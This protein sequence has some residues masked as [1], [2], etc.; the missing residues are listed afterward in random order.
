M[1]KYIFISFFFLQKHNGAS[2]VVQ[3]RSRM[4]RECGGGGLFESYE[5]VSY[6]HFFHI[7]SQFERIFKNER[8]NLPLSGLCGISLLL[9]AFSIK[10]RS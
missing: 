7:Y 10:R 4:W 1:I 3:K 5:F 8:K 2:S 6:F 9:I